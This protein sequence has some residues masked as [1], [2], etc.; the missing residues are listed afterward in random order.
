M[1]I[2]FHREELGRLRRGGM[3]LANDCEI[4]VSGSQT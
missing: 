3:L 1:S 4:E 2:Y